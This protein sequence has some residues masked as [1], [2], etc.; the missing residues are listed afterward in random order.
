M[1]AS[2]K[3]GFAHDRG[4]TAW[5]QAVVGKARYGQFI[6][7]F[8]YPSNVIDNLSGSIA[9]EDGRDLSVAG[10]G[11]CIGCTFLESAHIGLHHIWQ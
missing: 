7:E 9:G 11:Q 1:H 10:Q 3:H 8:P 5:S 4:Y 6:T 2:R